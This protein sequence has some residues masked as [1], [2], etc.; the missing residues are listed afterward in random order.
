MTAPLSE[1]PGTKLGL[2]TFIAPPGRNSLAA[3]VRRVL[4]LNSI[5]VGRRAGLSRDAEAGAGA[6]TDPL[7]LP[8]PPLAAGVALG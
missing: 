1:G 6:T 5:A 8:S 7:V 3:A 4:G 2:P